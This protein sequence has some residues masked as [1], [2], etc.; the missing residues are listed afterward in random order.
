MGSAPFGVA[1]LKG[2]LHFLNLLARSLA[3]AL[4]VRPLSGFEKTPAVY[5]ARTVQLTFK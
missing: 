1:G 3:Q 2:S 4:P 5:E